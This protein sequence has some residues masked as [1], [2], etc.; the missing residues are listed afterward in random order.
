MVEVFDP[1]SKRLK[2]RS[3]K[4]EDVYDLAVIRLDYWLVMHDEGR[5][6][7]EDLEF[8]GLFQESNR[9]ERT[10]LLEKRENIQNGTWLW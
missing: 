2:R 3:R 6:G 5:K 10:F 8:S 4:L 9:G 1:A 7:K